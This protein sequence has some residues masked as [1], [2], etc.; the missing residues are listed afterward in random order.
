MPCTRQSHINFDGHDDLGQSAIRLRGFRVGKGTIDT[1]AIQVF[2][3]QVT[4]IAEIAYITPSK[5]E[6]PA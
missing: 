3:R 2:R 6:S 5:A 1:H 4:M